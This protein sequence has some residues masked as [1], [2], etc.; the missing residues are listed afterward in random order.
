MDIFQTLLQVFGGLALFIYGVH[1]LSEG[2]ERVAGDRFLSLLEKATGNRFKGLLFGVAA[3]AMM[4]SSGLLMVTMIGLIN[5]S[6]LSLEQAIGIML[7]QEIGTT[8]TGQMVAFNIRGFNLIFLILGFYLMF[9]NQNKKC[10]RLANPCL[11]LVW[12]SSA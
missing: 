3:T 9:F 10:S 1:L 6:L 5:A 4:Q 7:G 12:F 11:V 8:I 2:L